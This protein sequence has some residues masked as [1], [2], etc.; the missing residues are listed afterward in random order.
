MY[1]QQN[2]RAPAPQ[3]QHVAKGVAVVTETGKIL[4][5]KPH[6]VSTI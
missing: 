2:P 6:Q 3:V 1:N 4:V 5:D